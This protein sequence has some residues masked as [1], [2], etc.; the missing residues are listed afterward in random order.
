MTGLYHRPTRRERWTGFGNEL[1]AFT[2]GRVAYRDAHADA[3]EVNDR[4]VR[5]GRLARHWPTTSISVTVTAALH[6]TAA[7]NFGFYRAPV[8]RYLPVMLR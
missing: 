1:V 3:S 5:L 6:Q 8:A 7:V 4:G 2:A